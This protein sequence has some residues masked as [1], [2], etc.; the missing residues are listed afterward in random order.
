MGI[1]EGF[2]LAS[3]IASILG[4]GSGLLGGAKASS[5]A[6]KEARAQ[7]A[8]D[9]RVTQEKLYLLDEEER[10]LAGT[11]R[12]RAAGAGVK[13]DKG[14][15]LTILAEQARTFAREKLFTS[16]VG[17]EKAAI[18]KQRGEN[19]ASSARYGSYSQAAQGASNAFSLFSQY[20]A[21][22]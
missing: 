10:E 18:T 21:M 14:S 19:V 8:T 9:L 11:T 20:K 13:A 6:K 1:V 5:A 16:Q 2:M 3:S 7:A 17:A 15:P 22:T 4:V 12:A